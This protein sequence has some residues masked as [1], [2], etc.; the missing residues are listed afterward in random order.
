[1]D[2]GWQELTRDLVEVRDHEEQALGRSE[3]GGQGAALQGT[4]HRPCGAGFALHLDDV[5]NRSPE[6]GLPSL[7][8]RVGELTHR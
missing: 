6:V 8:P 7:G 4:V 2:H 1:M 3:G 5:G